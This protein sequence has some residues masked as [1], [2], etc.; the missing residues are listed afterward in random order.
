[1]G[2][3][4]D[5][6]GRWY[7]CNTTTVPHLGKECRDAYMQDRAC[8]AAQQSFSDTEKFNQLTHLHTGHVGH[9]RL[10]L[11]VPWFEHSDEVGVGYMHA[12]VA[13][14]NTSTYL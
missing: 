2:V 4:A 9:E 14:V 8:H 13:A 12:V 10:Q 5:T 1:M 7:V 6:G 11:E 3:V